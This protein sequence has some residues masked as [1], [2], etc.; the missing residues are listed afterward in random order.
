MRFVLLFLVP[1]LSA[2]LTTALFG[3]SIANSPI[4]YLLINIPICI[5][6]AFISTVRRVK[7][8]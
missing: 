1:F 3:V 6:C 7:H 2:V 4:L 5:V 8:D